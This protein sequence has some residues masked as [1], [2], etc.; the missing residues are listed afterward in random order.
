MSTKDTFDAFQSEKLP[1]SSVEGTWVVAVEYV[2]E[3]NVV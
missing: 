2:G 1:V 3:F